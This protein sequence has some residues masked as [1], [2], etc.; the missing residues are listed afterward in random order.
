[1]ITIAKAAFLT[2]NTVGEP[3]LFQNGTTERDGHQA[4]IVQHPQ[5]QRWGASVDGVNP[6][7]SSPGLAPVGSPMGERQRDAFVETR[8]AAVASI[9]GGFLDETPLDELDFLVIYV[10]TNGSQGAIELAARVPKEKVRFILC[11]CGYFGKLKDIAANGMEEVPVLMCECG[12]RRTMARL[13]EEFFATG[14]V[15]PAQA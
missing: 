2:Y 6:V 11:D 5:G 12:G 10:G 3:G 8:K 7:Q 14:N 13:V 1:V 9:Y 4:I 15:G